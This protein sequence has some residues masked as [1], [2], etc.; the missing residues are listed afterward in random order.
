MFRNPILPG[1]HPDPSICRV[2]ADFYLVTSTFEYFPGIPIYHSRDLVNWRQ[3]GH[4]LERSTQINMAGLP[5][6]KGVYAPTIRHHDG[7]FYIIN[8]YTAPDGFHN[9]VLTAT[10][11][12]G[13]W[14][15]P[16]WLD[17][18]PGI[19]PSLFFEAE[20]RAWYTGN[21]T[22]PGGEQFR[23][24]R[25][26]W[27]QELDLETM[28]LIGDKTVLWNGAL[29]EAVHAEAPH[30]YHIGDHYYLLIAEGGTFHDHAVTIA[31]SRAITGPYEGNPRNPILT[32]RHL[33]K[34]YPIICTGHADL[35]ET[36]NGEW[37][38]VL[39]A[40]RR[41]GGYH[42]NLGRETFMLPVCWEDDWPIASPGSGKIEASY[43]KPNLPNH[44][45]PT[46][47]VRDDFED[48][49]LDLCWN[50]LR[51]P[52]KP[53]WSLAERPGYLR[54]RLQLERLSELVTPS[55]IGRRQEHISFEAETVMEFLPTKPGECAG[56]VLLQ[57]HDYHYRFVHTCLADD[58]TVVRLVQRKT[59]QETILAEMPTQAER[60]YLK[61][62]AHEQAYSFFVAT[63]PDAWIAL[64]ENADGRVLST[65]VA[66]GFTGS[67][68]GMYASS[69]G[70]PSEAVADFDWFDY[71]GLD[72]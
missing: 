67:Y 29:R 35:V 26:I 21:R 68:L 14:S 65:T 69:N 27:L 72:E 43:P 5:P 66:G 6:S 39:L 20:G 36:S 15:N 2:E 71:Q 53:F 62:T 52:V 50:F 42:Y 23:A 45:W 7:M 32:H 37:W 8:T 44:P 10:D 24:H 33:G 58:V 3:I 31:R 61:V 63:Q 22:P 16:Y 64:Y 1:F 55:F 12:A 57:N 54:L 41:Y 25:E 56:F 40:C 46:K 51:T 19:D 30:V 34:D 17:D 47:P 9:Y 18:A 70:Q 28:Q 60:L 49:Q 4:A 48:E 11:P 38:M 13:P 59:G